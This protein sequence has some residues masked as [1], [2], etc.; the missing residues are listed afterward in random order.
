MINIGLY[1]KTKPGKEKEFEETFKGVVEKL[2]SS[3][4]V[5]DAKLYKEIGGDSQYMI[6]SEWKDLDSFRNFIQSKEFSETTN[7]G[8]S[9]IDGIPRHRVF[10]ELKE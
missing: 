4:V 10:S 7:R 9:I 2:K 3:G 1:Y 8:K 6:Y 5:I